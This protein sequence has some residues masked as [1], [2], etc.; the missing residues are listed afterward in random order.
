GI[1]NITI[2][3]MYDLPGQNLE[4]WQKT[5]N[6]ATKLPITHLSLYNLTFE[7]H[8]VFYKFRETLQSKVPHPE[9]SKE[10]YVNAI[11]ALEKCGLKQYEISAFAKS[12]Y[13]SRHNSGYW[14][15]HPFLGF[16]P[17]AF[18]YWDQKRFR[19]VANLSHYNRALNQNKDPVDFEELLSPDAQI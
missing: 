13:K 11:N 4:Q 5:L 14:K 7:P 17:S 2:D 15:G 3:L 18:S 1:N 6:A 16:G 8:T 19:N 12:G 10:M 9:T